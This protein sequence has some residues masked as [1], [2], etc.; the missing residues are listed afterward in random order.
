MFDVDP[1]AVRERNSDA[2]TL[3]DF[4]SKVHPSIT[5]EGRAYAIYDRYGIDPGLFDPESAAGH[6]ENGGYLP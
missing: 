4:G 2:A 5:E 6:I 3:R 1:V